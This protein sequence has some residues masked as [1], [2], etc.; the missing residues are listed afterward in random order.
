MVKE[1]RNETMNALRTPM[2]LTEEQQGKFYFDVVCDRDAK[3]RYWGIWEEVDG[4]LKTIFGTPVEKIK[5]NGLIGMAGIENIEWENKRG[6][7]SLI[8]DPDRRGTGYGDDALAMLL[9][10]GFNEL[11]LENIWGVCYECNPATEFWMRQIN[12]YNGK[13]VLFPNMKFCDGKYWRG[14]YFNFERSNYEPNNT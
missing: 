4:V 5:E 7:I 12:K 14:L 2:M 1:W 9:D 13:H 6:E 3:A 10:K 11:N 8:I